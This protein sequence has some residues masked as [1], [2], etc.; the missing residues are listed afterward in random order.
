[1]I[2]IQYLYAHQALAAAKLEDRGVVCA[3]QCVQDVLEK[4]QKRRAAQKSFD[5][6]SAQL[7]QIH[8]K[9]AR[10]THSQDQKILGSLKQEAAEMKRTVSHWRAEMTAHKAAVQEALSA[11]P[12]L[13]HISTPKGNHE[14]QNVLLQEVGEQ[15]DAAA[16]P[17]PH[18]EIGAIYD[19]IDFASGSKVSGSGFPVYKGQGAKLQRALIHFFIE[20]ALEAGYQEAQVPL[21]VNTQSAYHAGHLPDKEGQMYVLENAPLYLVPTAEVPLINLHSGSI[22]PETALPAKYV[23]HTPCFRREA[24]SWGREVRGLNRL[25]QFDKVEI[26]QIVDPI[27]S[28]QALESMCTHVGALLK[29]LQLPYRVLQLC[30]GD[31]GFSSACTY[32]FEVWSPGQQ[33]WLEVSSVSN[34]EAYQARRGKL[35]YR[36]KEGKVGFPHTLNGSAL[37]LPRVLAALLEHNQMSDHIACPPVLQPYTGFTAIKRPSYST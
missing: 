2:D 3:A 14:A 29:R 18:W 11:L 16:A 19:I 35:R 12:N 32:D 26:V 7:N 21:L 34:C 37:A 9:V 27:T 24:G 22:L 30:S 4:D 15:R 13:P 1:M 17:L 10:L 33:R 28:Y 5:A 25:H 31:L 6:A 36:T 20:A 8:T 23:A